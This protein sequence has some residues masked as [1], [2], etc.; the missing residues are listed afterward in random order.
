[1][2]QPTLRPP[3]QP[4]HPGHTAERRSYVRINAEIRV[5]Y[6]T[7]I[8]K[9]LTG[10][11]VDLSPN[12]AFLVTTCPFD[13]DD[14]VDL[15]LF[16]PG[17][18]KTAVS[19][20]ARVAWINQEGTPP[21][22]EYPAGVGLHFINLKPEDKSSIEKYLKSTQPAANINITNFCTDDTEPPQG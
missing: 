21:K 20:I 6:G 7:G 8:S 10:H 14:N 5:Y 16:I 13:V 11:S 2:T 15:K 18:E 22:P 19:C 12:G 3:K 1:M 9:L 4:L 17:K